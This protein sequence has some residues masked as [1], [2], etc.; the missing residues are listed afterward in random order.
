[1]IEA[2]I[3]T[4]PFT[5]KI[6]DIHPFE[7]PNVLKNIPDK[8]E[9][10][11]LISIF[12]LGEQTFFSNLS[13]HNINT[14]SIKSAYECP[15]TKMNF[16]SLVPIF[17]ITDDLSKYITQTEF[18]P[19]LFDKEWQWHNNY[20]SDNEKYPFYF[21]KIVKAMLGTGYTYGCNANDGDNSLIEVAI[22]L[23]NGDTIICVTW[24]WYNK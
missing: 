23:N 17:V 7:Y 6:G 22:E 19:H 15:H 5:P 18:N 11:Y 4:N 24:E 14:S 10:K 3:Q 16:H 20:D 1:M 12:S 8:N 2:I 13:K 9:A 21:G